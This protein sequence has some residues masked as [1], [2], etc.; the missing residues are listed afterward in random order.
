VRRVVP[1][2]MFQDNTPVITDDAE[3]EA[4]VGM[5]VTLAVLKRATHVESVEDLFQK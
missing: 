3:A 4:N 1:V 5:A 2:V